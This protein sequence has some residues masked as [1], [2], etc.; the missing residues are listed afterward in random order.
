MELERE[1]SEVSEKS[2]NWHLINEVLKCF[3]LVGCKIVE[4]FTKNY[5]FLASS[6]ALSTC[7]FHCL[8][9]CNS[10]ADSGHNKPVTCTLL[11]E[12][13]YKNWVMF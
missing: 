10:W 12:T 6:E 2:F 9:L 3:E 7:Q 5:F 13:L 1:V 8:F 11:N 4:E